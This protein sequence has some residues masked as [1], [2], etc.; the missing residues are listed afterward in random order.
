MA[1]YDPSK[2]YTWAPDAKFELTGDEF[3]LIINMVRAVLST[4]EAR[5][6]LLAS[7]ANEAIE[8]VMAKAV[9]A[10]IVKEAPE[11]P[12]SSGL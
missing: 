3:G 8:E 1:T 7:R 9:E 6:V 10:D 5:R 12:R 2:R 11:T 4:E